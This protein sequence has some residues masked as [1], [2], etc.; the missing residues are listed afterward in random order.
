MA[1]IEIAIILTICILAALILKLFNYR[2]SRVSEIEEPA[3][4]RLIKKKPSYRTYKKISKKASPPNSPKRTSGD[5]FDYIMEEIT[6][7]QDAIENNIL[8][9]YG[10]RIDE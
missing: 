3:D 10:E 6:S 8:E 9:I 1:M 7:N 5:F 2:Y 4:C